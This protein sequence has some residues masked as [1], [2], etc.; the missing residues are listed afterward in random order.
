MVV[1]PEL[2]LAAGDLRVSAVA[3]VIVVQRPVVYHSRYV[4]VLVL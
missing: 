2:G 3:V 1:V 4:R